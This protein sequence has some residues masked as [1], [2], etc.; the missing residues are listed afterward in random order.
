MAQ[1]DNLRLNW[2][3][4][5]HFKGR[6]ISENVLLAH[7]VISNIRLRGKPDNMV[8]KLDMA[9]AYDMVEWNFLIKVLE[10]MGFGAEILD[11]IW[12][13]IANNWYS[14]IINGQ[15]HG[16]FHST[17]GVKQGDP[18]SPALFILS[19][20]VL[21][22]AMNQ[23][24]ERYEYKSYGLPKWSDKLNH[25]SYADDTIIFAAADNFFLK[26]IM[27]VLRKYEEQSGQ[28]INKDKSSYYVHN[29]AAHASRQLVEEITGFTRGLFPLTYLGCPIG[30][31]KKKKVYFS[32][33]IKKIQNKL[34]LWKGKLLTFGGEIVLINSV[35]QSIPIY[36]LSVSNSP[37]CVIH[38]IHRMFAKFMWNFK[39]EGRSTHWI[40]WK[41]I[42]VPK[43]EGGLGL[44]SLFDTSKALFAK[45]WWNFRTTNT[46]W[47]NYMWIKYCKRHRPQ[48]IEWRG[49]SQVWKNMILARNFFDQEIWWEPK[50]GDVSVW[51]DNWTQLGDLHYHM[52]LNHDQSQVESVYELC[53]EDGW[54]QTVL[55]HNLDE[56]T[57]NHV[58]RILGRLTPT[59][60]RDKPWWMPS[61]SGK[62]KETFEHLFIECPDTYLGVIQG[63]SRA[64]FA[65]TRRKQS[66]NINDTPQQAR[67]TSTYP[68]L[69][70][71]STTTMLKKS[72]LVMNHSVSE[73]FWRTSDYK[74]NMLLFVEDDGWTGALVTSKK[75]WK[76]SF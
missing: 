30:H 66:F 33:L 70:H 32:M 72:S 76:R 54:N 3:K 10:K 39:E 44:R 8:I 13:L 41:D 20:E 74:P 64:A 75:P 16:F 22:R 37:K 40:A 47:S 19:A 4:I 65:G 36:L 5:A 58:T 55:Q 7:E 15:N 61:G 31:A 26:L 29:K 17:R 73:S 1:H 11:M 38:D 56:A 62:F 71:R 45:L 28:L 53:N 42:C 59:Q 63:G 57:C 9:K 52:N 6:N 12:R 25:L 34:Q 23:L 21:S 14:V 27:R 46:L 24:Y 18:L 68:P 69:H 49:G 48:T 43:E 2:Q 60:E 51:F 35:L 67:L 50:K